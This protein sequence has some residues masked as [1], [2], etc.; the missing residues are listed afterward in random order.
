MDYLRDLSDFIDDLPDHHPFD[1]VVKQLPT[2]EWKM[3]T[4]LR[5]L[6]AQMD[7]FKAAQREYQI[8]TISRRVSPSLDSRAGASSS[9]SRGKQSHEKASNLDTNWTAARQRRN[10]KST[11]MSQISPIIPSTSSQIIPRAPMY[12]AISAQTTQLGNVSREVDVP[13]SPNMSL[14][15]TEVSDVNAIGKDGILYYIPRIRRF[16]IR[17][18]GFVLQG[19]IGTV[20]VSDP[21]PQ[22]I[23][24]CDIQPACNI[25]TCRYYHNPLTCPG[26]TDIRNFAATSW[27]YHPGAHISSGTSSKKTRKLSSRPSLD[28]DILTITSNDL[29][30]YNEQLMHDILCGI[31]MNYFVRKDS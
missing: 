1:P 19:N 20:Y 10:R 31:L 5:K 2:L 15:C 3:T 18:A 27:L 23:H 30:Y 25:T 29:S 8:R 28:E 4:L 9:S 16:A 21:S 6:R 24:D 22:K 17:L 7:Q 26:S 14:R 11:I 13:V 12:M